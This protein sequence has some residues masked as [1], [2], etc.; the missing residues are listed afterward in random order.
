MID[1]N[2]C[3]LNQAFNLSSPDSII[4]SSLITNTPCSSLSNGQIDVS[5]SGGT[6][7]YHFQWSGSSTDTTEDI[8]GLP[9]GDYTLFVTDANN[10]LDSVS[11]SVLSTD[12]VIASAGLDSVFC[13][14]DSLLLDGSS[15]FTN[16]GLLSYS[17]ISISSGD[18]IGTDSIEIVNPDPGTLN[19]ILTVSN[20]NGC[21]DSD[22][23]QYEIHPLPMADAG[24]DTSIIPG[25]SVVIGGNPTGPINSIFYWTP[26][27]GLNDSLVANPV[28]S[29]TVAT[30]YVVT[31]T[32]E[33][34]CISRDTM[35]LRI[36]PE[37]FIPNG[38]S[39]NSDGKNDFWVIN[40]LDRFPDNEVEIYNRWGEL[41]YYKKN[42]DNKWDGTYNGKPL[43]IGTYY[44]V[45]KLNDPKFEEAYTG[46]LTLF[47]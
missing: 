47:K 34:G 32:D 1:A 13:D 12:T 10:C 17:W 5:V 46:P 29:A 16:S 6:P 15:S 45:I 31:V 9:I 21:V 44:Y 19:F 30:Q 20:Q 24:L 18:T 14:L 8:S 28:T 41:L 36:K 3:I 42:Y 2:G 39:P 43:P 33:N 4:I 11:L 23:V 37:I 27:I 38:I 40:N 22:S 35:D 7:T 26:S 25:Q